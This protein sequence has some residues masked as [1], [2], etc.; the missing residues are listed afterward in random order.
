MR[1]ILFLF[2][3]L[4]LL[5]CDVDTDKLSSLEG[6]WI[7]I[8]DSSNVI[9]MSKSAHEIGLRFKNDSLY[10][11]KNDGLYLEGKYFL[12]KNNM[13]VE[14]FGG[15]ISKYTIRKHSRDTLWLMGKLGGELYNRKLEFNPNLKFE[16]IILKSGIC[17]GNCPEFQIV[18]NKN[19]NVDFTG[20]NN[21]K[22]IGTKHFS[23]SNKIQKIDSIFKLS[24]IEKSDYTGSFGSIDGWDMNITFYYNDSKIK[25]IKGTYFSMPYR[26]KGI[27]NILINEVEKKEMI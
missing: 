9:E 26:I 21:V 25:S 16:K 13:N 6:E 5:S 27:I 24:N 4:G 7:Y 20:F 17:Y 23:M 19:G 10:L 2:I 11:I 15:K 3:L 14:V 22:L 12:E 18:L 1:N 8:R